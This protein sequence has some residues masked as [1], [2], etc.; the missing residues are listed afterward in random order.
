MTSFT[1][2]D[3]YQMLLHRLRKD[4]RGAVSPEEFESFLRWRNLDYYNKVLEKEGADKG[5]EQ[6]LRPFLVPFERLAVTL[7]SDTGW[8]SAAISGLSES[9]GQWINAWFTTATWNP[10]ASAL[11]MT[12][13]IEIDMVQ[14][15]ELPDRLSNAITAPSATRPV[16]H[17]TNSLLYVHGISAVGNLLLSYYK[18]PDDPVY[19]YYTNAYGTVTY[20]TEGQSAYILQAGEASKS[21][22]TAGQAV[23]SASIDLEW[24]DDEAI[25][26]LDMIVSDVSIA[27]SDPGSFQASLLERKEN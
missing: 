6:A 4:R 11:D 15:L 18:L 25:N 13:L 26:I 19:D 23:T 16:G 14:E 20:L 22:K 1:N 12:G 17:L 2:D 5:V 24:D 27:L 10:A 7:D 8:Y 3:L 9:L 21:G